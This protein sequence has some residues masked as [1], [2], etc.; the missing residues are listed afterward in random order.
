MATSEANPGNPRNPETIAVYTLIGMCNPTE[1][2]NTLKK[3]INSTPITTLTAPLAR[4]FIGFNG[5][6]AIN[7]TPIKSTM[8]TII[9]VELKRNPPLL[10]L[11][12]YSMNKQGG[13]ELLFFNVHLSFGNVLL[14]IGKSIY[15][16]LLQDHS[17]Q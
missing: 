1:P 17:L 2:A 16:L 11:L 3:K 14:L 5:A 4:N 10:V 12:V 7:R 13:K 15:T 9:I 8:E 6:P